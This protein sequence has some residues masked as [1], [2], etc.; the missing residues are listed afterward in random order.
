MSELY[1][2]GRGLVPYNDD[3]ATILDEAK[4]EVEKFLLGM[5]VPLEEVA[6]KLFK[7]ESISK[8]QIKEI[9]G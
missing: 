6:D 2:M 5:S 3:I 1:G 7:D 8:I 4:D 9:S